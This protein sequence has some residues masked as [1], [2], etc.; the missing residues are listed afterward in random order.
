MSGVALS[1]DLEQKLLSACMNTTAQEIADRARVTLPIALE[2]LRTLQAQGKVTL[3]TDKAAVATWK[4][5]D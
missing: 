5:A 4:R 1:E 2:G 3:H